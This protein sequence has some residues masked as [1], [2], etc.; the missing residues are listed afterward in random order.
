MERSASQQHV[1]RVHDHESDPKRCEVSAVSLD[2]EVA[3][4]TQAS[5]DVEPT[6]SSLIVAKRS[7]SLLPGRE[8]EAWHF[9]F[10]H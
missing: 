6:S 3:L 10:W 8:T 7:L 5:K 2:L 9:W 1:S 4:E